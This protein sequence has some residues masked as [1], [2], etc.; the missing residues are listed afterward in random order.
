MLEIILPPS[1]LTEKAIGNFLPQIV[2]SQ[3]VLQKI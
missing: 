3:L 1:K 2:L